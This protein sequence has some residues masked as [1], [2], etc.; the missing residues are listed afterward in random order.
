MKKSLNIMLNIF[1]VE[2]EKE[3]KNIL[4]VFKKELLKY[5]FDGINISIIENIKLNYYGSISTLS[6]IAFINIEN[7]SVIIK[8]FEK[9]III[10]ICNEIN[11]LNLD[12]TTS[13]QDDAIKVIYP[14]ITVERR[15]LFIKKVKESGENFKINM[16]N[17]RRDI[18]N[19]IKNMVKIEKYSKDEEKKILSLVQTKTDTYIKKIDEISAKKINILNQI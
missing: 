18:N 6:Q 4:E 15:N 2:L 13:V 5:S 14:K 10:T 16:R 12:L 8:P 17:T 7:N 9:S 11:K 1:L 19:K 3:L